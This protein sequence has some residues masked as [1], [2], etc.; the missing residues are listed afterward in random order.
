MGWRRGQSYSS[1]LR[2]RVLAA[3]DGGM[4]AR[5]AALRLQVSGSKNSF[6]RAGGITSHSSGES[7][8]I[9]LER[10]AESETPQVLIILL[11][12]FL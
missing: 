9:H 5:Q 6:D 1:D 2:A 10:R 8:M 4:P 12:N 3:G 7:E 11:Y